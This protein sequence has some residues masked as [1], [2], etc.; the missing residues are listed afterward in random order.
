MN[1]IEKFF[2]KSLKLF[3]ELS[4][5]E[6]RQVASIIVDGNDTIVSYGSNTLPIGVEKTDER[7]SKPNKYTWIGH[8]E[9]NAIYDAA[10]RGIKLEGTKMYC[11]YFP[12][13]DCARGIIQSGISELYT[14][15]PDL[16]HEKWGESWKCALEMFKESGV[17]INFI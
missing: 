10:K 6:S 7:I 17:Q 4:D 8:A 11:S 16:T 3:S 5:D 1:E 14:T 2:V 15:K 13:A 12:C 9:R